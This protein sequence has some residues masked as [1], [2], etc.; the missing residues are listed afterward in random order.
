L[1]AFAGGLGGSEKNFSRVAEEIIFGD[2]KAF[3][4]RALISRFA[5]RITKSL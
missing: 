1:K 2:P 5:P 4:C 3:L